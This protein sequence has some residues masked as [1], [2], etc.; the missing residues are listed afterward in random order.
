MT[1]LPY[2]ASGASLWR[3]HDYFVAQKV[4]SWEPA[5]PGEYPQQFVGVVSGNGD[6]P[7]EVHIDIA[8]PKKSTCSCPF[9]EGRH[10]ICKH[11]VALYFT[12]FPAEADELLRAEKQWEAEEAAR[13]EAH[14]AEIWQY[15][16]GLK[17]AELQKELFRALLEI[18]GLRDRRN[19]W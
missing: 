2:L 16:K 11:M 3:G 9:A 18:D 14:R 13:E 15:V 12:V 10:V 17:K 6:R 5:G 7:Y 8:H 19:W 1:K 4:L